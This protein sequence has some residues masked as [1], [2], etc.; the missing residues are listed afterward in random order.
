MWIELFF[1][2]WLAHLISDFVLQTSSSCKS[3]SEGHWRSI[4]QYIH[5]FVVFALAWLLSWDL[6]FWWGALIVGVA[7]Y[8]IDIWKSY[9]PEKVTWFALDQALHVGVLAGVSRLWTLG[10][11]WNLPWGIEFKYI[12]YAIATL[13]CW[14]PANIFIKLMLKHYSVNMPVDKESGFNAGALIGTIERWLILIFV[15]MQR[16]DALGLLIA[17]KSIIRFSEKDTAKTEYV[18]AGTLLSI[19]I[20]LLAGMMVTGINNVVDTVK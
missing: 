19:F 5:A 3:K 12:V 20:A 1:C 10:D 17:A 11:A 9:R 13:V 16:Y 8:V 2:L 6:S 7:H 4:H 18:L 15:C 14:K